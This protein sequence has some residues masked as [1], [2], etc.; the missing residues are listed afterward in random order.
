MP[1]I[2]PEWLCR[3]GRAVAR[4]AR[5]KRLVLDDPRELASREIHLLEDWYSEKVWKN[6]GYRER[7]TRLYN[8]LG[9]SLRL[10][11]RL[12]SAE[13]VSLSI[14]DMIY[15]LMSKGHRVEL[16][17]TDAYVFGV[18]LNPIGKA[19]PVDWYGQN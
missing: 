7:A 1:S 18:E 16:G 13:E 4:L 11:V 6:E 15:F 2:A 3:L 14:S 10:H 17:Y 9:P 8:G 12:H 19:Y 5:P